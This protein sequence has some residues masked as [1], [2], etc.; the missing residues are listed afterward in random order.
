MDN[1]DANNTGTRHGGLPDFDT[2]PAINS[3]RYVRAR[4]SQGLTFAAL[5]HKMA[6][7]QD[8]GDYIYDA[9]ETA[10]SAGL[11]GSSRSTSS[12]SSSETIDS[13]DVDAPFPPI[14]AFVPGKGSRARSNAPFSILSE[15]QRN[16]NTTDIP[17]PKWPS[18]PH[19]SESAPSSSSTANQDVDS[20]HDD[21]DWHLIDSMRS[22]WDRT[23]EQRLSVR[24]VLDAMRRQRSRVDSL[25][26]KKDEAD[27][28]LYTAVRK[29]L[30][31]A[32]PQAMEQ[33]VIASEKAT[34]VYQ[35]A[36]ATL[37]QLIDDLDDSELDLEI[38]EKRFYSK[39]TR[40]NIPPPFID[41]DESDD[42]ESLPPSRASL[43]GISR[44]RPEDVHPLFRT[45]KDAFS[46]LQLSKEYF[47]NLAF[48]KLAMQSVDRNQLGRDASE[49]L[50]NFDETQ[51]KAKAEVE[52]WSVEYERLRDECRARS[53]I[54]R[55]SPFFEDDGLRTLL[56]EEVSLE[57]PSSNN[58]S[59]LHNIYSI[60]QS[61]P[62]HLF[63]D[64]FPLTSKGDLRWALSLPTTHPARDILIGDAM[65]EHAIGTLLH[66][67]RPEDKNDFINRW[68][69]QKLRLSSMEVEVLYST[70]STILKVF[71]LNRWQRDVLSFWPRDK[72]VRTPPSVDEAERQTDGTMVP[73]D[74]RTE[75]RSGPP[76]HVAS[77]PILLRH[78]RTR[79]E[80]A[81][82]EILSGSRSE[83]RW[84]PAESLIN[85]TFQ[86]DDG[87]EGGTGEEKAT[88]LLGF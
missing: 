57:E 2:T 74:K 73:S 82:P 81:L 25:R 37:D 35:D 22:H 60:L 44:D 30:F 17:L 32:G 18:R 54:P 48:K 49:F 24:H 26:Q 23:S 55:S 12:Y 85:I 29:Q 33:Y 52:H 67:G 53:L 71:D 86:M 66:D 68:L 84:Q 79:G 5:D 6:G 7:S 45:M 63:R 38:T 58:T 69:L 70:F 43:R 3:T 11:D 9:S 4:D 31:K 65:Q 34:L 64:S 41:T 14:R 1:S 20:E 15:I 78:D 28:Q 51:V 8:R 76:S 62:E 88:S 87:P 42:E 72:A 56:T 46:D 83:S 75:P 80:P 77:E 47:H 39:L 19:L 21:S 59:M 36:Q 40:G 50:D 10:L 61:N 16:N 13:F 27:R